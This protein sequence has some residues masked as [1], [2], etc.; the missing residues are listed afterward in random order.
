MMLALAIVTSLPSAISSAC[1]TA[2][3]TPST[4]VDPGHVSAAFADRLVGD[5][6]DDVAQV[7]S[8]QP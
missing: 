1:L 7:V 3:S 4:N 5:H 8:F 2:G 6:D